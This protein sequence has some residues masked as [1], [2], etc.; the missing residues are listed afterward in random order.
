MDGAGAPL[1]LLFFLNSP[2]KTNA[3]PL[4]GT[5]PPTPTPHPHLQMKPP[6]LKNKPP[7]LKR[8]TTFRNDSLEKTQ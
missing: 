3:A 6:H 8:E 4:W 5:S 1:I 7:P 2:P